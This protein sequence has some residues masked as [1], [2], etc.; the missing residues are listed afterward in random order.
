MPH[1]TNTR[2][3]SQE[4]PGDSIVYVNPNVP[5]VNLPPYRGRRYTATVPDTL[6][7]AERARLAIHAMTEA[8]NP[9]A[10]HE[11]YAIVYFRTHPPSMMQNCWHHTLLG[12]FL[13]ALSLARLACGSEQNLHVDQRWMEVALRMQ[14]PD[15]LLYT[16]VRGRPW[17]YVWWP[18]RDIEQPRDQILQP[19]DCAVMLNAMAHFARRDPSP[20]WR[21]ALRSLV[22][23]MIDLAV[24]QGD[25]A[26]FWP[27]CI[28][29]SKDRPADPPIPTR[30][31]NCEGS[32]VPHGLVNA[33]RILHY[34]PALDLARKYIHIPAPQ[35]LCLRWIVPG[36]ARVAVQRPHPR[37]HAR[38]A[39]HAGV[40]RGDG[41]S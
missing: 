3:E 15:G 10:D 21:D 34:E 6:D 7:L 2:A 29:A 36:A 13:W 28:M 26:F 17:A 12:K 19:F 38:F 16:P 5:S 40:R 27:S 9:L 24:A 41:R 39:G 4:R 25:D 8:T 22:D 37:A 31:F 14:G 23:G 30:P 35:L 32:V 11:I 18:V 20:L 33:W 1:Q